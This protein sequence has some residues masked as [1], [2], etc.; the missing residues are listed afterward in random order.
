MFS[1]S[2]PDDAYRIFREQGLQPH[3]WSNQAG[4]E[5]GRHDHPYDKLLVCVAGSITFHTRSGD[6]L[7]TAGDR[8]ELAAGTEHSATVGEM[9]VTCLEAARAAR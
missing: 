7:L 5:Y 8:L 9:G 6:V 2:K 4:F 3:S 1:M